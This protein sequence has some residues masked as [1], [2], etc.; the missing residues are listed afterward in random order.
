VPVAF[1]ESYPFALVARLPPS[2]DENKR[3]S[4]SLADGALFNA[5]LAET[6]VVILVIVMCCTKKH[7]TDFLLD[8]LETEG[9]EKMTALLG[10]IFQVASSIL[11]CDAFPRNWLNINILAHVA[12]MRFMDPISDLLVANHVPDYQDGSSTFQVELWKA[13][14]TVVLEVLSSDQLVIEDLS[15]QVIAFRLRW[16]RLLMFL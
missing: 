4:S 12:L 14:L 13:G 15:P 7:I 9:N 6:A 1:P 3:E 5:G 8:T 2:H 10:Q 11:H 16:V